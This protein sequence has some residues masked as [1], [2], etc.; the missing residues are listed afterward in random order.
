MFWRWRNRRCGHDERCAR[1]ALRRMARVSTRAASPR[2]QRRFTTTWSG[3]V[4]SNFTMKTNTAQ[5][6]YPPV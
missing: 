5:R 4:L 3:L 2:N 1:Q 6:S